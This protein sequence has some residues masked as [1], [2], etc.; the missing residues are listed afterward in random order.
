M[1][2][3]HIG[4]NPRLI[5]VISICIMLVSIGAP[6]SS[7]WESSPQI[8]A[9][10]IFIND[11]EMAVSGESIEIETDNT[12]HIIPAS[13]LYGNV[14]YLPLP[15]LLESGMNINFPEDSQGEKNLTVEIMDMDYTLA[16]PIYPRV[17]NDIAISL[18]MLTNFFN[19]TINEKQFALV[20]TNIEFQGDSIPSIIW[21]E[22]M[23]YF[24][25]E[26]ILQ[27]LEINSYWDDNPLTFII[28]E[29]GQKEKVI[30]IENFK[31]RNRYISG[32]FADVPS[33]TWFTDQVKAA[34][35]Y[36]LMVGTND[37]S[38]NPSGN[39]SIAEAITIA[40]RLH[41]TYYANDYEFQEQTPW[42]QPYVDYALEK[43]LIEGSYMTYDTPI[44][45]SEF[46]YI[47]VNTFPLPM[48]NEIE[49]SAIP[50]I[51]AESDYYEAVY[52]LYRAGIISGT[53]SIGTF[54]PNAN[55]SRAEVSVILS[56]MVN[57]SLR[58][59]FT[60]TA[61]IFPVSISLPMMCTVLIDDTWTI[62]VT[63]EPANANRGTELTW[64]SNFTDFVEI[65]NNGTV[66]GKQSGLA[67]ITATTGNGVSAQC[68]VSVD[69]QDFL[70]YFWAESAAKTLQ[71]SLKF[72]DT[73]QIY[74]IWAN[75]VPSKD[76]TYKIQR[77]AIYYS[78]MNSLGLQ[79]RGSYT[80]L[81]NLNTFHH[82]ADD[83]EDSIPTV[84]TSDRVID[85][86]KVLAELD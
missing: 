68:Y 12:Q 70:D 86:D 32:Q 25:I 44:S 69:S 42:Y 6:P 3:L 56:S 50:D 67:T 2:H 37:S 71:K 75:T 84:Y 51:T 62:P 23:M 61:P 45:R 74:N 63:I 17:Q 58:K 47:I 43:E 28:G 77:I 31:K 48:I 18:D 1:K 13:L 40:S 72:P 73:L 8:N 78:A 76:G 4:I 79:K 20:D 27:V 36:G 49:D 22:N 21:K 54:N 52:L 55:I 9:V 85:V 66:T 41:S 80:V 11:L 82:L 38:F 64:T 24:P 10:N 83:F 30:G 14:L 15:L 46:A 34:F 35:E 65:D 81:V 16:E 19:I 7:A 29:L 57:E 26:P 5:L 60:M 33:D 39:I 59:Q 53:D